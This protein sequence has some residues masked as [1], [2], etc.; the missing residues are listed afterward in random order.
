MKFTV[1]SLFP[2]YFQGPLS[3]GLLGKAVEQGLIEVECMFGFHLL[4]V[5]REK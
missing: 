5:K 3:A 4:M 2:E 1:V